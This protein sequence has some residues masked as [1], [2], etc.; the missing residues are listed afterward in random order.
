MEAAPLFQQFAMRRAMMGLANGGGSPQSVEH[1]LG[2][3]RVMNP[4]MAKEMESRY[5]PGVGMASVPVPQEVRGQLVA[6]QQFGQA[7]N[8][9]RD[10]AMKHSGSMSPSAI[11]EGQTKAANVQNLYRQGING[12]VFKQGEQSFINGIIDSDPSKFFNSIRVLPKLN[13]AARENENSMGV[14]KKGYGLQNS[15]AQQAPQ[16]KTVNGKKYM[17]GPSGEAIPIK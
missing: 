2:Y 3:M 7:V 11:A 8:D 15:P 9:L 17:R 5:V 6:K 10:W 4:E 12:G 16:I 1:M 13:E 14:L